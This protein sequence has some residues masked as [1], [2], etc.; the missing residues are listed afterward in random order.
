MIISRFNEKYF[1][2]SKPGIVPTFPPPSKP[3]KNLDLIR[4]H[5]EDMIKQVDSLVKRNTDHGQ[6]KPK[7]HKLARYIYVDRPKPL[8]LNIPRIDKRRKSPIPSPNFRHIHQESHQQF[9]VL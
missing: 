9:F 4:Q 7:G 5:F 2:T 1:S 6:N 3:I 8:A